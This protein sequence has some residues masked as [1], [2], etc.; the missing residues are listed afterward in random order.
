[1][2]VE[3]QRNE[4]CSA[5]MVASSSAEQLGGA[6]L[7]SRLLVDVAAT[8]RPLIPKDQHPKHLSIRTIACVRDAHTQIFECS[9]LREGDEERRRSHRWAKQ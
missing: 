1:M 5:V 2:R 9:I 4:E 6:S 3:A 7:V 8:G